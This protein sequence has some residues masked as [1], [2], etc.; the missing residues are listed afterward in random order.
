MKNIPKY[1]SNFTLDNKIFSSFSSNQNSTSAK[2]TPKPR[3]I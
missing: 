3:A 2:T 1:L